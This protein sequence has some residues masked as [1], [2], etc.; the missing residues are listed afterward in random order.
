[1]IIT[2]ARNRDDSLLK[3]S[4]DIALIVDHLDAERKPFGQGVSDTRTVGID[5]SRT[6]IE[7]MDVS[8]VLPNVAAF[9]RLGDT[10]SDTAVRRHAQSDS[11]SFRK[12]KLQGYLTHIERIV[13]A[14]RRL[15]L[16]IIILAVEPDL[17]QCR[18]LSDGTEGSG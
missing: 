1:Q 6:R 16:Q 12:G 18:P 11:Q 3:I 15:R 5:S 2:A 14:A 17:E 4:G 8:D 9:F 10:V 13:A 7:I